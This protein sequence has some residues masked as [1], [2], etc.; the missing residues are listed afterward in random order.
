M[1]NILKM[2]IPHIFSQYIAPATVRYNYL[3]P[4]ITV[5][6]KG[7]EIEFSG[8]SLDLEVVKKEFYNL[9]YKEKI[10]RETI[11]IRQEI[12]KNIKYD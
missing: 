10:Y 3:F 5:S 7:N 9:L 11:K 8:E 1:T 6:S 4:K 12:Y 2:S